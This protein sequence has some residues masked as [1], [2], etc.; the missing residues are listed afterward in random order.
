MKKDD[1]LEKMPNEGFL[2]VNSQKRK[3]FTP[4]QKATLNRKG[5][6]L[7]NNGDIQTAK[8][9]FLNTGYTYGIERIGDYYRK[10]GDTCEALRM[11]WLAPSNKKKQELV[12][13]MSQVIR[14]WLSEE[15]QSDDDR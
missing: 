3:G 7:Y 8:R 9:I 12:K 13:E 5:N 11:Y 2:K 4:E 10:Q 15:G 1:A 6:E 14:T